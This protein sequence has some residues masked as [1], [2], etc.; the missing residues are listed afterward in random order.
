ME[1]ETV[2]AGVVM[3]VLGFAVGR[4]SA[5]GET[6]TVTTVVRSPRDADA[7]ADARIEQ[8]VRAGETILAVK[9]YR[10]TYGGGLKEAKDAVDAIAA[11]LR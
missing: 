7:A 9:L 8:H 1:T 3:L 6:R 11:R 2:V 10:E 4:A 5:R